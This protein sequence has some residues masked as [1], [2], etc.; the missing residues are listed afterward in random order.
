MAQIARAL[1]IVEVVGSGAEG[2]ALRRQLTATLER[3]GERRPR[4]TSADVESI[5]AVC[6]E[7]RAVL[8]ERDRGRAARRLN[9]LLAEY[10]GPPRLVRHEGWDWHLHVDRADDA[11]WHEW[12]AASASMALAMVLA[13]SHGEPPWGECA[14]DGCRRLFVHDGRGGDRRYCSTT[15]ATRE[16]VRRHR[17]RRAA[18]VA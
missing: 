6:H 5:T 12:L 18:D 3:H 15:C 4:L 7:L 8:R 14:G 1:A 9:S 17:H 16:R 10:A 13:Q 11:P 2:P